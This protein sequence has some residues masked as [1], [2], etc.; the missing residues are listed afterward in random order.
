[1]IS[2]S[3]NCFSICTIFHFST[4]VGKPHVAIFGIKIR[5]LRHC[6]SR[7]CVKPLVVSYIFMGNMKLPF[8]LKNIKK[9]GSTD[10]FST[11]DVVIILIFSGYVCTE[12]D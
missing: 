8:G 12:S 2:Y 3:L 9:D 5:G 4:I 6:Q 11:A 1:M 10:Y 7:Q